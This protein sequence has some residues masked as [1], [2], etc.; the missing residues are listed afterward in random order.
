MDFGQPTPTDIKQWPNKVMYTIN[1]G[2]VER[3]SHSAGEYIS[4]VGFVVERN[5]KSWEWERAG[6]L[7][8]VNKQIDSTQLLSREVGV[9]TS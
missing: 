7:E 3:L 9:Y 4:Q 8:L 2:L 6:V 1:Q 5:K